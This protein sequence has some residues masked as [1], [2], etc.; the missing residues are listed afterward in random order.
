M[1]LFSAALYLTAAAAPGA[2]A[3][4]PNFKTVDFYDPS[5]SF[6]ATS[7]ENANRVSGA[8]GGGNRVEIDA[9]LESAVGT[10]ADG[11][12]CISNNECASFIAAGGNRAG[13]GEQPPRTMPCC[14]A[15]PQGSRMMS[16]CWNPS[17]C[18]SLSQVKCVTE[19]NP[20]VPIPMS[21]EGPD[22]LDVDFLQN[23]AETCAEVT[24]AQECA[25]L[26]TADTSADTSAGEWVSV[27]APLAVSALAG[28]VT[29]LL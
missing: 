17:T 18:N 21:A 4:C 10:V 22:Q 8:V 20:E 25:A 6:R 23:I 3:N 28:A 13:D 5:S 2:L 24:S 15:Y 7:T 29:L 14:V 19:V 26:L 12:W 1:K 16:F 9:A 11:D 27:L